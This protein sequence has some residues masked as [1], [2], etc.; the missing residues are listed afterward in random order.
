MFFQYALHIFELHVIR[1][2]GL[3]VVR[4]IVRRPTESGSILKQHL[5]AS[6][7]MLQL[8]G[9]VFRLPKELLSAI[10]GRICPPRQVGWIR[11]NDASPVNV[12]ANHHLTPP[13]GC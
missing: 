1:K 13:F 5:A 10:E 12:G 9:E 2:N 4:Q 11:Q 8:L 6:L 7:M 3:V